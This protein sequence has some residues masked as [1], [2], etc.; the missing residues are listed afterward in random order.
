MSPP[1]HRNIQCRRKAASASWLDCSSDALTKARKRAF[2]TL[3]KGTATMLEY[4][5]QPMTHSEKKFN[6]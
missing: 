4:G 2:T 5:C 3:W 1:S 6:S